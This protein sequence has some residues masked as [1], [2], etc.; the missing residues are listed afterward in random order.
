MLNLLA[1][2]SFISFHFV[3][4]QMLLSLVS[5]TCAPCANNFEQRRVKNPFTNLLFVVCVRRVYF[6]SSLAVVEQAVASNLQSLRAYWFP[7]AHMDILNLDFNVFFFPLRF[8]CDDMLLSTRRWPS[9]VY[10]FVSFQFLYS[11]FFTSFAILTDHLFVA[12]AFSFVY[13]KLKMRKEK[14]NEKRNEKIGANK[15]NWNKRSKKYFELLI[16]FF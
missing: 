6:F 16:H 5:F 13:A 14:K 8:Y 11:T 12:A 7:F 1:L 3:A 10:L 15:F 2:I 9:I 4:H